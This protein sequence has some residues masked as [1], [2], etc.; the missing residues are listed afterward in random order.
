M[1]HSIP[2]MQIHQNEVFGAPL[3]GMI[4]SYMKDTSHVPVTS[5]EVEQMERGRSGKWRV[6]G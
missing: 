3:F 6:D 4:A 2:D 5:E 1:R